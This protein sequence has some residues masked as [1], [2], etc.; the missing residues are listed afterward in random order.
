M[1]DQ[2]ENLAA[3]FAVASNPSLPQPARRE[4]LAAMD[5]IAET[6]AVRLAPVLRRLAIDPSLHAQDRLDSLCLLMRLKQPLPDQNDL[7]VNVYSDAVTAVEAYRDD[8]DGSSAKAAF[9]AYRALMEGPRIA[10]CYGDGD[11]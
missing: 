6:E 9:D 4:A 1:T 7:P 10:R 3:L 8:D 5:Q 2:K 11:G